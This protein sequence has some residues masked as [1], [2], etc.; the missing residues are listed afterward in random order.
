MVGGSTSLTAP[1]LSHP[2]IAAQQP[3]VIVLYSHLLPLN[4]RLDARIDQ[5]VDDGLADE[6][7]HLYELEQK[8]LVGPDSAR[9]V[10][11]SIGYSELRDWVAI[12][13]R[14]KGSAVKHPRADERWNE[15]VEEMKIATRR[16]AGLQLLWLW[17]EL[18]P[19][20]QRMEVDFRMLKVTT[21]KKFGKEVISPAIEQCHDWV[22][23][24]VGKLSPM[25]EGAVAVQPK[26]LLAV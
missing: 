24:E 26:T 2:F 18:V 16:Y 19:A 14:G 11:K 3:R 20:L 15:G 21:G 1:L 9:G 4:A 22:K 17:K 25:D 8:L 7:Y 10:W 23:G 5:M 12:T 13:H 6:V